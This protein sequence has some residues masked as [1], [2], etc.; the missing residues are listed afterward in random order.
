MDILLSTTQFRTLGQSATQYG[1]EDYG[2]QVYSCQDNTADCSPAETGGNTNTN[3]GTGTVATPNTG[4]F[5]MAQ[6]S[7]L[8]ALGGGTLVLIALVCAIVFAA[9]KARKN[10]RTT[11]D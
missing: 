11:K 1:E 7:A 3:T 8:I 10:K 5:G 2:N 4:F 6:D 9:S